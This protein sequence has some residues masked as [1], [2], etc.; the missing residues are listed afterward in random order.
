MSDAAKPTR[1]AAIDT[2][3]VAVNK[4]LFLN[5]FADKG[6]AT[7]QERADLIGTSRRLTERYLAGEVVPT[8]PT[9]RRI[10]KRLGRNIDDL[11]P[12]N[13]EAAA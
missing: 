9:A 3:R 5:A 4:D 12:D 13:L 1:R 2:S 7:G 10:A 6:C 11:W 8:L